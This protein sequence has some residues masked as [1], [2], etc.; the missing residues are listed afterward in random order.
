MF[1]LRNHPS[2]CLPTFGLVQEPL[3]LDLRFLAGPSHRALQQL[4]NVPLQVFVGCYPDGI[5]HTPLLQRFVNLR[6]GKGRVSPKRDF[7]PH[8]LLAFDLRQQ[9]LFPSLRAVD[10]ASTELGRQTIAASIEQ[11]HRMIT[12]GLKVPVV[13]AVLLFPVDRDLG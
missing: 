9:K 5:L 10:I 12:G 3:V 7:F 4:F 2:G 11:K 13:G 8:Q 6:L 1:Y